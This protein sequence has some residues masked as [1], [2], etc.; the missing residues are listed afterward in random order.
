MT[1]ADLIQAGE[2]ANEAA[3]AEA[4]RIISAE[5]IAQGG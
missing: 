1:L 5:T 4:Q 3:I 2:V